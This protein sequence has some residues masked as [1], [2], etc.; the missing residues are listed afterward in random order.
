PKTAINT[1]YGHYEFTVMPFGLTN[2][3]ATFNRLMQDI[4]REYLDDFVLVFFDDILIYSKNAADHETHVRKVLEILRK[5]QLFAKKSKCT[6]SVDHVEYL[7][8][9][10]SKDGISPDSAKVQAVIDWPEPKTVKEV[11]GFLGLTGW[12]RIFIPKYAL[13]ASPLTSLLKKNTPFQWSAKCQSAFD[14]LKS[15]LVTYPVLKLPD[16]SLPFEVVTDAS[17]FALGGALMQE[18]HAVAYESRKLR[19]HEKNY[20]VHDLELL[21]VVYALKLWRHY[22]L[23]QRF[24]LMTDH[25]SLKWIFTQKD[26]NMRQRRWM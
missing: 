6:F 19:T 8:F 14:K 25:Q 11:R 12:Y 21:S 26:L 4:L 9:L 20:A 7:G 2:A 1:R 18:G 16:F 15:A 5:H 22:L 13:I 3:P 10:V 24:T 17:G 23:G